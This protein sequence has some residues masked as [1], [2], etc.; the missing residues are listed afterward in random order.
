MPIFM[1]VMIM[2]DTR[3]IHA[4]KNLFSTLQKAQ[5]FIDE[6]T[7]KFGKPQSFQYA[8]HRVEVS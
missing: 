1:V 5:I 6:Q 3:V 7:E 8:I 2:T 4:T